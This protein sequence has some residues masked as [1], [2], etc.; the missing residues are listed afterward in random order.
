MF[1]GA[2]AARLQ[3]AWALIERVSM[4]VHF[5]RTA[6]FRCSPPIESPTYMFV[7]SIELN[8]VKL[9]DTH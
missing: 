2:I 5:V 4:L 8:W 9:R 6:G 1:E 7:D 3:Q